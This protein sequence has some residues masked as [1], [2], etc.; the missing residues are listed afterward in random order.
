MNNNRSMNQ[1]LYDSLENRARLSG[2]WVYDAIV[3]G[4]KD[5]NY[6][7]RRIAIIY[8]DTIHIITV[9]GLGN[10]NVEIE[11]ETHSGL[12]YVTY[13]QGLVAVA[14][15]SPGQ[16]ALALSRSGDVELLDEK[17]LERARTK[18]DETT[19]RQLVPL[20]ATSIVYHNGPQVY[21]KDPRIVMLQPR[22]DPEYGELEVEYSARVLWEP[23]L[24]YPVAPITKREKRSLWKGTRLEEA[25]V[26]KDREKWYYRYK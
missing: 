22:I 25:V 3:H 6:F 20:W 9:A 18:V 12:E 1:E 14:K 5:G 4:R 2:A 7:A 16:P 15:L 24:Q 19:L 11:E 23:L 21:I 8:S 13:S 10:L 26:G 17:K